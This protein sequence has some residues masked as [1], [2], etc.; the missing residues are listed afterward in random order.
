MHVFYR[1][2]NLF[3]TSI[4][5]QPGDYVI[6]DNNTYVFTDV[7]YGVGEWNS[8]LV[9]P[10]NLPGHYNNVLPGL[11]L[12]IFSSLYLDNVFNPD[13]MALTYGEL[14]TDRNLNW[15]KNKLRDSVNNYCVVAGYGTS[16]HGGISA[17]II[18]DLPI[19]NN[20]FLTLGGDCYIQR[21][22]IKNADLVDFD[23]YPSLQVI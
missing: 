9:I 5:Y 21:R 7:Q 1:V 6:Y 20:N 19:L 10:V 3:E 14:F 22:C 23:K 15:S 17:N 2:I 18:I 13:I 16:H 4:T 11:N 8:D 12:S